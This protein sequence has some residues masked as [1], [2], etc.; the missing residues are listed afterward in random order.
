VTSPQPQRR[1]AG[2]PSPFDPLEPVLPELPESC[3]FGDD[4]WDLNALRRTNSEGSLTLGLTSIANAA[5]QLLI[6]EV[7]MAVLNPEHPSLVDLRWRP[8]A[9]RI[10]SIGGLYWRLRALLDELAE[11]GATLPG[12]DHR[13]V[14]R[15]LD[16]W[17]HAGLSPATVRSRISTLR[18]MRTLDPILT[19]GGL[20]FDPW[21]GRSSATIVGPAM[22]ASNS[23]AP[24]PWELWSSLVAGAWLI[25]DRYSSDILSA[26]N[27]RQELS[28]MPSS[29]AVR[30]AE[31]HFGD[32][33]AAGGRIPLHTGFEHR[34]VAGVRGDV[35]MNL[36]ARL[37]GIHPNCLRPKHRI[38]NPGIAA[39]V[40]QAANEPGAVRLGGVIEPTATTPDGAVWASEIGLGE[41]EYLSSVLR[42]ACYVVIA[43]LTGMRDSE[44][45]GLQ[46]D[47]ICQRDGIPALRSVQ[48][49]GIDSQ[50]GE[51]RSW[52]APAPAMRAATVLTRLSPHPT[53][54]FARSATGPFSSYAPARDIPRLLGFLSSAP[55]QRP[56]RGVEL[57]HQR[58]QLV[59]SFD[60][61][62]QGRATVE[63]NQRSLRQSF[64]IWAARHPEAELGLGIQL[65]HASLR[66]TFGYATDRTEAA[67]RLV[68]DRRGAALEARSR[69]L[70]SGPLAG[71]A[72]EELAGLVEV[73][74]GEEYGA[75]VEAVG[76][77]LYVGLANDCV[78][79]DAR[80]ACGPGIPQLHNHNCAATRCPNCLIGPVHAPIWRRHATHLDQAI[81]DTS[82]PLLRER[83][84][85]E[86]RDIGRVLADLDER[87]Q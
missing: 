61:S 78:R 75:L 41:S 80:A 28:S 4:S 23:T 29:G 68:D 15:L 5:D 67:V 65:G 45:Q 57:G 49:K 76:E 54:L 38:F 83:L 44:I 52:W 17:T 85:T 69:D 25:V 9:R 24:I 19:G 53:F 66:Q 71:P 59:A 43:A 36:M 56:G 26:H 70:L 30:N 1:E 81:S 62:G 14:L 33:L 47:S 22:T 82:Q 3:R 20:T 79:N 48:F 12:A 87:E 74:N 16:K 42:A 64:S 34:G 73:L 6:R 32:W 8:P 84:I 58:L 18:L 11:L 51:N 77:R 37:V 7:I 2:G 55:E 31:A 21:P 35:N 39:A 10:R 40:A 13:H 50:D 27:R 86:R 72:G 60:R 63:I 46:R